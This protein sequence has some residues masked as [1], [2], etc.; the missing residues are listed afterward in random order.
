MRCRAYPCR[1][2]ALIGVDIG[3]TFTD[4]AVIHDGAL[5]TAKVSTTPADQSRGMAEAIEL[6]L[7]G[8]GV[9]PAAVAYLAHA[10]T[11]ATTA[12]LERRGARTGFVATRGFGDL[13][14]LARQTR[15]LLYRPCVAPP[16]PRPQPTFE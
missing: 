10:T 16:A 8:A 1:V 15:P 7:A 5:T 14:A 2:A 6:A 11:V 12:V 13:L 3:G 4:A 9:D